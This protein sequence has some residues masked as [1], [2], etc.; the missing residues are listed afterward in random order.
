MCPSAAEVI[1]RADHI[2]I[3][4][5]GRAGIDGV[6]KYCLPWTA[7]SRKHVVPA[8]DACGWEHNKDAR[9]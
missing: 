7:S 5:Q 9:F 8:C 3:T 2:L 4:L 6:K 1:E